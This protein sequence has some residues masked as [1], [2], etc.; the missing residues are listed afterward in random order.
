MVSK[1]NSNIY[2]HLLCLNMSLGDLYDTHVQV[3][4]LFLGVLTLRYADDTCV[5]L[6]LPL[7]SISHLEAPVVLEL[8]YQ[9]FQ[10]TILNPP[11]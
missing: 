2:S 9:D 1:H 5:V 3:S 10:N 6:S 8:E 7:F 4:S 11:G